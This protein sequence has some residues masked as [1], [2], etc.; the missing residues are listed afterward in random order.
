MKQLHKTVPRYRALPIPLQLD[1]KQIF[2]I[3][4]FST[5]WED[6]GLLSANEE[7][8]W[9]TDGVVRAGILCMLELDRCREEKERL[10]W[11]MLQLARWAMDKALAFVK[12][13]A[14]IGMLLP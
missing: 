10:E 2:H 7:Q 1:I 12:V 11:E 13:Y 6:Y 4:V 8:R 5:L 3:D 9:R 14:T